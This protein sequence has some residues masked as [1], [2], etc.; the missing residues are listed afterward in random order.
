M[1]SM[2]AFSVNSEEEQG[3]TSPL[4][5][6]PPATVPGRWKRVP[7]LIVATCSLLFAV[8]LLHLANGFTSLGAVKVANPPGAQTI[9]LIDTDVDFP[10]GTADCTPTGYVD[11]VLGGKEYRHWWQKVCKLHGG[12]GDGGTQNKFQSCLDNKK[13]QG[14]NEA[15]CPF[16]YDCRP[17]GAS[18]SPY[19]IKPNILSCHTQTSWMGNPPFDMRSFT[20]YDGSLT[21]YQGWHSDAGALDVWV[22]HAADGAGAQATDCGG[23]VGYF[24]HLSDP[25]VSRTCPYTDYPA[26]DNQ[27]SFNHPGKGISY[28]GYQCGWWRGYSNWQQ[29]G[30]Y[31]AWTDIGGDAKGAASVE[32]NVMTCL[33]NCN[34]C[35]GEDGSQHSFREDP[36]VT[37]YFTGLLWPWVCSW[38][39]EAADYEWT[40]TENMKCYCDNEPW[41]GRPD[42]NSNPNLHMKLIYCGKKDNKDEMY[43]DLITLVSES[44]KCVGA[45]K[46]VGDFKVSTTMF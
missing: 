14:I 23:D 34:G 24:E 16:D 45:I 20:P 30:L 21:S 19:P 7:T 35:P 5:H 27:C 15:V 43:C 33:R 42:G 36:D 6:G 22:V 25:G 11:T 8:G 4:A 44:G 28:G 39:K 32:Q 38:K 26:H 10:G 46:E 31:T 13:N 17:D 9:E 2:E 29:A 41:G 3:L 1:S 37:A 40:L 12:G 18:C